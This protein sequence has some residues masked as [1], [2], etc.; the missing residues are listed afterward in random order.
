[1]QKE[2]KQNQPKIQS[3]ES[4]SALL[5]R[6][7]RK[8]NLEICGC[9]TTTAKIKRWSE[10]NQSK[11]DS[12]MRIHFAKGNE[13]LSNGCQVKSSLMLCVPDWAFVNPCFSTQS[14][15]LKPACKRRREMD[16]VTPLAVYTIT[17]RPLQNAEMWLKI[18][19]WPTKTWLG[20]FR[21]SWWCS[22][23]GASLACMGS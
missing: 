11:K 22:R 14:R 17:P 3:S 6:F 4:L 16:P 8:K 9:K 20:K 13:A 23:Y 2:Q 15:S 7:I 10:S 1:M 18:D 19:D 5:T 21:V 12:N